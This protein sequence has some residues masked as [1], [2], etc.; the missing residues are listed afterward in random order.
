MI[1]Q[2]GLAE[3]IQ[4]IRG[5]LAAA[6][7]AGQDDP[8]GFEVGPVE[9]EFSM[10]AARTGS[11]KAGIQFGVVTAGA[12][13]CL[14]REETHRVTVTLQPKDRATGRKPEVN[15]QIASIPDR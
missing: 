6:Q 12:E 7:R 4:I 2:V 13:G 1:E 11:G 10:V 14:S 8:I 5:E 3:A 15:D 9:I